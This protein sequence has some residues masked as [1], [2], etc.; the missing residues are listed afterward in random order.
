[1]G[2]WLLSRRTGQPGTKCLDNDEEGPVPEGR[3]KSLS[4]RLRMTESQE[5]A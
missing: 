2:E 5:Q 1:M 4:D 3:L